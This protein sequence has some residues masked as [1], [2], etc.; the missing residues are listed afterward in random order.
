MEPLIAL[1]ALPRLWILPLGEYLAASGA[2]TGWQWLA[3][4]TKADYA[5]LAGIAVLGLVSIAC[6]LRLLVALLQRGERVLAW[7]A[8]L[9]IVVLGAAALGVFTAGG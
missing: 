3:V 2:P 5:N 7:I 6:Y 8:A 4:A 9:Q 1:E